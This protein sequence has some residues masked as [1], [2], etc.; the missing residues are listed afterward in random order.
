MPLGKKTGK[1]MML[2]L[3]AVCAIAAVISLVTSAAEDDKSGQEQSGNGNVLIGD[4]GGDVTVGLKEPG[5]KS[6]SLEVTQGVPPVPA[7]RSVGGVR[8]AAQQLAEY[9]S[10]AK[11]A[12][13]YDMFSLRSRKI[14]DDVE[15]LEIQRAVQ[16]DCPQ[17]AAINEIVN[18]TLS[19]NQMRATVGLVR[20]GGVPTQLAFVY[21]DGRWKFDLSQHLINLYETGP[22]GVVDSLR[23]DGF[24][25][26]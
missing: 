24:C 11:F 21:Q 23:R 22:K 25:G 10:E 2:G 15:Y 26:H 18:P 12:E 17:A 1:V 9:W 7:P 8:F 14:I 20:S 4:V 3:T 5:P 16:R 13:A 6:P 19:G